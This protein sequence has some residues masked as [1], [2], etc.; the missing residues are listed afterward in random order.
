MKLAVNIHKTALVNNERSPFISG[1]ISQGKLLNTGND[2]YV[3]Q[4]LFYELPFER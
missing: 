3:L 4:S 1:R 2:I